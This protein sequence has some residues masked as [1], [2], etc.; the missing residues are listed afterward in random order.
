MSDSVYWSGGNNVIRNLLNAKKKI[1]ESTTRMGPN[2]I[3][4]SNN[5]W[6]KIQELFSDDATPMKVVIEEIPEILV[7]RS[8]FELD[9]MLW[10]NSMLS[11]YKKQLIIGIDEIPNEP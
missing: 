6:G 8:P 7:Y 10:N 9:D 3:V 2:Q 11:D 1:E 4:I 5:L